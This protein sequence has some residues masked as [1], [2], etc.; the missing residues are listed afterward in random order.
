MSTQRTI[1]RTLLAMALVALGANGTALA[2]NEEEPNDLF[3]QPQALR[4]DATGLATIT[5]SIENPGMFTPD[6]DY[7]SFE[8]NAG[9]LIALD[10]DGTSGELDTVLYVFD[11]TG[12]MRYIAQDTD[13]A[14]MGSN[15]YPTGG[16][17]TYDPSLQFRVDIAGTWKVAV[18]AMPARLDDFGS[19]GTGP[20][21]HE[22]HTG[23]TYSFFVSRPA[24]KP[25]MQYVNI[26]IK[27]GDRRDPTPINKAKGYIPVALLADSQFDPFKIDVSSLRFGRTG[28]EA[29]LV[30]CAQHG[31]RVNRD[32][33]RDRV[34]YFDNRK[35]GFT[36][37]D[38]IGVLKGVTLGKVA[39]EGKDDVKVYPQKRHKHHGHYKEH[40]QYRHYERHNHKHDRDDDD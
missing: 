38:T 9:E 36:R 24:P 1:R 39:F 7:Y 6:V 29:S 11:P 22:A 2:L 10:I 34:C 30:W 31:H 17:G 32:G 4:F 26:D 20:Q 13:P 15:F 28:K 19:W 23:G 18:V 27:P 25:S 8:G 14:D 37:M 12:K 33:K 3:N 35:T 16:T 40:G 5:G 21:D